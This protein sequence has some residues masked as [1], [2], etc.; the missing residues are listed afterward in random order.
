MSVLSRRSA[1]PLQ[2]VVFGDDGRPVIDSSAAAEAGQAKDPSSAL[3]EASTLGAPD[4]DDVTPF[5]RR[6]PS[7]W[8]PAQSFQAAHMVLFV[9]N[10][11]GWVT[12][13]AAGWKAGLQPAAGWVEEAA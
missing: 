5:W 9:A 1:K 13:A 4:P 10:T 11:V 2:L 7:K 6:R 3:K 8:G 12:A